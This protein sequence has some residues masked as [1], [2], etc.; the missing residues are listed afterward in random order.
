[1]RMEAKHLEVVTPDESSSRSK[2]SLTAANEAIFGFF[3]SFST[4]WS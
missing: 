4:V 1:M 2:E 3:G